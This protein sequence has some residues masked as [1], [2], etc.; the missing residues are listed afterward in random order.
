[1]ST[2]VSPLI[3][4]PRKQDAGVI[5][6][7]PVASVSSAAAPPMAAAGA[8]LPV[9]WIAAGLLALG[10]VGAGAYYAGRGA[11]R[12]PD[13]APPAV[14][15]HENAA[16]GSAQKNV[17]TQ[18][19]AAAKNHVANSHP[20]QAG[21]AAAVACPM[22]GVV[23]SVTAVQ[24]KGEGSGVGAVAGTVVGGVLGNQV[25]GGNGRTAMTVLGAIGGA[26]AGNEVEKRARSVT[27]YRVKVRTDGGEVRTVE[28]GNSVAVG[29]RVKVE[30]N[31][32]QML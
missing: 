10:A 22:C 28:Q 32:L 29:Q 24:H 5:A 17:S 1:M 19:P 7:T 18:A 31:R 21:V 11:E 13:V 16:Q 23:E 12:A 30:G 2:T 14:E 15:A 20:G 26:V 8:R 4:E 25:G 27:V 3:V 9:G 6:A